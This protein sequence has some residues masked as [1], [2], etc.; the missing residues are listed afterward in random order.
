MRIAYRIG[1]SVLLAIVFTVPLVAGGLPELSVDCDNGE[2]LQKALDELATLGGGRVLVSGA[3][4][5]A[6]VVS[7]GI[8]QIIG[9]SPQTTSLTSGAGPAVYAF[10]DGWLEVA[11][12][13]MTAGDGVWAT[14][15]G[16]SVVVRG[17]EI[18]ADWSGIRVESGAGFSL[19]DSTVS[20]QANAIIAWHSSVFVENSRLHDSTFAARLFDAKLVLNGTEV[21]DNEIGVF[22]E[23]RS[24]V[25]VYEGR[26]A[27]NGQ[28]HM[29]ANRD[30]RI[31]LYNSDVG[32]HGDP[33]NLSLYV[34]RGS[35][36]EVYNDDL[37]SEIWGSATILNDSYISIQGAMLHGSVALRSFSRLMLDGGVLDGIVD[38]QSAADAWC[39]PTASAF[40]H[41]C[42]SIPADTCIPGPAA[43]SGEVVLPYVPELLKLSSPERPMSEDLAIDPMPTRRR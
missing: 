12:V 33:T 1:W 38:C 43:A 30:S 5:G 27:N 17:C 42:G 13:R 40:T 8:I 32:A 3:C 22:A 37:Q 41:G 14:G 18:E 24:Q 11:N 16:R 29:G 26:F 2:L 25:S 7:P 10:G 36:V 39:G 20:G 6:R 4:Y 15:T 23:E 35:A 34:D 21:L 28:G 31:E 9:E 19:V